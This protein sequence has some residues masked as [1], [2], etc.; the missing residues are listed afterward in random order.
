MWGNSWRFQI[1]K[2]LLEI[3]PGLLVVDAVPPE[4]GL[5]IFSHLS[6]LRKT[7]RSA[8]RCTVT[9]CR[10]ISS[11]V[12]RREECHL[13]RLG[14]YLCSVP[15]IPRKSPVKKPSRSSLTLRTGMSTV[16][17]LDVSLPFYWW[18]QKVFSYSSHKTGMSASSD[19]GGWEFF[20][21][22]QEGLPGRN[23]GFG[24]VLSLSRRW[25]PSL[26]LGFR[27]ALTS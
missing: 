3:C 20:T 12:S 4:K 1:H 25:L 13:Q 17:E 8:A 11:V 18:A 15:G 9:S 7:S 2:R 14:N 5:G 24:S 19:P 10:A 6:F 26:F 21:G 22:R 27:M 16:W 23:S